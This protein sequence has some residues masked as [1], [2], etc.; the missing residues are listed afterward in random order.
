MDVDNLV[1]STFAKKF[2]ETYV[3]LNER[4]KSLLKA[5][6]TST[7]QNNLEM[8]IYLDEELERIKEEIKQS[9]ELEVFPEQKQEIL[10]LIGTY[11]EKELDSEDLTKILKIQQLVEEAKDND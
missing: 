6:L 1:Y 4:Q 3:G 11:S 9:Q 7:D 5:F 10:N 8:K 2:N